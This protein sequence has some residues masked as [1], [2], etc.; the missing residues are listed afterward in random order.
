MR[1][2]RPQDYLCAIEQLCK[3]REGQRASTGDVA[4]LLGVSKGTASTTLKQLASEGLVEHLPYE[5]VSLTAGGRV[6]AGRAVRRQRLLQLF[7]SRALGIPWDAMAEDAK[8]LELTAS[9]QLIEKIE[10]SLAYPRFDARGEP[11][12]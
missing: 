12:S 3:L 4:R 2:T 10:A 9:D 11:V 7:L 6:R 5:G 8:R 1:R